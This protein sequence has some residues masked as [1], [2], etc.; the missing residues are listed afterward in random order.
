MRKLVPAFAV[1]I[2]AA[3][4]GLAARAGAQPTAAVQQGK[5]VGWSVLPAETYRAGSETSGHFLTGP[6]LVVPPFPNQPVQGFSAIH[7]VGDGSFLVMS[8][9]GYG[10]KA[11]SAR[12][13]PRRRT[14][15]ERPCARVRT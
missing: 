9:N 8:D 11:R 5:L 4:A 6:Q 3:G 2:V 12:A 15:R 14:R 13:G 1:V 10:N 7:P